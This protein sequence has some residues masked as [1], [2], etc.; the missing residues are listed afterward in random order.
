MNTLNKI[1]IS[2]MFVLAAPLA[3]ACDYPSKPAQMPDGNSATKEEMLAG[4]KLINGYQESMK[5]YLS[6]IEAEEV[7]AAQASEGADEEAKKQR[8]DLFNKKYN[9]AVDEQA[10]VVEEFNVQIRAYKSRSN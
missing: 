8:S 5:E 9:A 2:T 3:N 10:L 1:L 4:V 7:L 6:C